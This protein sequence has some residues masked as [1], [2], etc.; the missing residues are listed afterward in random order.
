MVDV[1]LHFPIVWILNNETC[2]SVLNALKGVYCNFGL[3]NKILT[4]NGPRFKATEFK[5]FHQKLGVMTDTS[6]AYN[7]QSVGS[8]ERMVQTV[9]QIITKNP[10]NTWLALL[11]YKA[12][13][14]PSI[15]KSPAELLN[16]RKFQTNPPIIDWNQNKLNESEIENLADKCQSI[17]SK[18]IQLPKLDIGMRVLYDKNPDSTN[19]K[20]PHW[21]KC[22]V[23]NRKS[24]EISY[25][26]Q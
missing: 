13:W 15:N 12:T 18:D 4:D 3:P 8:V 25:F 2:N 9:K 24:K 11:I 14:I 20:C 22:T 26:N 16:S 10:E 19:I 23:K 1:T 17:T 7:H 6:S 5:E 21:C